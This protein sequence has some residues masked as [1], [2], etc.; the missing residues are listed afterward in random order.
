MII[1]LRDTADLPKVEFRA[2]LKSSLSQ[3]ELSE[4]YPSSKPWNLCLQAKLKNGAD[5]LA[6][7][8][9]SRVIDSACDASLHSIQIYQNVHSYA[10]PK[11]TVAGGVPPEFVVPIKSEVSRGV[12]TDQTLSGLGNESIYLRLKGGSRM[13]DCVV[14]KCEPKSKFQN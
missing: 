6:S 13:V 5:D 12:R 1:S 9:I 10:Y 3:N 14:V 7:L 2:D 11:K 8:R 4:R